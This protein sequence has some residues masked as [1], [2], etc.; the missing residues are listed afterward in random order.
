MQQLKAD[1][2]A[3]SQ[4]IHHDNSA[5]QD[6]TYKLSNYRALFGRT[7][8]SMSASW[9]ISVR[10]LQDIRVLPEAM[11]IFTR[12]TPRLIKSSLRSP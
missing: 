4:A 8:R 2:A 3:P 6:E 11:E 10:L 5:K 7:S 1:A 9:S 12:C